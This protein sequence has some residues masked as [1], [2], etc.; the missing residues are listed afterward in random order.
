M[1]VRF[2]VS[3]NTTIE[4]LTPP[5]LVKKLGEFDLD[6]CTPIN[7]PFTHAK[8]NYNIKD[9]GLEKKWFGRVYLNPPYGK[10]MDV[11]LEKLKIHKNGIALIFARTETKCFFK[12]IWDDADA[13]LFVKGRI[14]FLDINGKQKG[15][16][17]A[18]SVFIAYGEDNAILLKKSK[19]EGKF[20]KLK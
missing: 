14:K 4:W 20:I 2:E 7:P 3:E 18:P 10:G 19:I 13:V 9:N 12:H 5:E 17:G 16:P 8:T 6:P 1:D 11:W 15:T